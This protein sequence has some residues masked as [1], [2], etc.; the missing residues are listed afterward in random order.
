M[1]SLKKNLLIGDVHYRFLECL[2]SL[3]AKGQFPVAPPWDSAP[4][5]LILG[6]PGLSAGKLP[7]LYNGEG[8][9]GTLATAQE[10]PFFKAEQA[11]LFSV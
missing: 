7:G 3:S 6:Y 1:L 2:P 11:S 8:Q 9:V 4:G 5:S 10:R